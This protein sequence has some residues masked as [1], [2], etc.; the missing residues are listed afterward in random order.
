MPEFFV[1]AK[2]TR[3]WVNN[4]EFHASN[5]SSG[6]DVTL[7]SEY[8]EEFL[9]STKIKNGFV[10]T[11]LEFSTMNGQMQDMKGMTEDLILLIDEEIEK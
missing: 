3:V 6:K 4:I 1:S 8:F 2:P 11:V 7:S 5:G 9:K 10:M